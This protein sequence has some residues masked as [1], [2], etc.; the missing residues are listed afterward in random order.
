MAKWGMVI[1]LDKCSACQSCVV[2]CRAENNVP[3][4]GEKL[5]DQGR[6]MFWMELLPLVEGE[7]PRVSGRFIPLPC[8]HCEHPPCI[9]VCPVGATYLNDEGLVAQIYA[10]CIGCRFC[11]VACPYTRRFFNWYA[12]EWPDGTD[13]YLNPDVPK[14]PK[15]VVEK[16]SFCVQRIRAAKDKAKDEDREV[17]DGEIQPACVET[18]PSRAMYF[19][20]LEDPESLVSRLAESPRAFKLLEGLGTEPKVI[21]MTE[22]KWH[23][24][25]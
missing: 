14:R 4:A 8:M 24:A 19:G 9:K 13:R 23:D 22:E 3:F 12:P 7:Y 15:G 10:R 5:T 11:T 2:A 6:A 1:D 18:C 20:D 16:C 25:L 17:E 21:Y